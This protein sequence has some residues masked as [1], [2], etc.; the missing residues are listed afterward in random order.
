MFGLATGGYFAVN[1]E[2]KLGEFPFSERTNFCMVST[3]GL[4]I[5]VL[6]CNNT[7]NQLTIQL[8]GA[9]EETFDEQR[10]PDPIESTIQDFEANLQHY[11]DNE[12]KVVQNYFKV[13]IM[14][15]SP[16]SI[17]HNTESLID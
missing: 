9:D 2:S 14:I 12:N 5:Y 11:L 7:Q 13:I 15:L 4:T 8:K 16:A 6:E 17:L 1:S 3:T 10:G